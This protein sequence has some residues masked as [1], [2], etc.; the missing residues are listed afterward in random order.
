MTWNWTVPSQIRRITLER[1]N[2]VKLA[3]QHKK[4]RSADEHADRKAAA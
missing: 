4:M 2:V 1:S 3:L